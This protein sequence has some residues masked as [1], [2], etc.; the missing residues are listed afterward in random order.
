MDRSEIGPYLGGPRATSGWPKKP[1]L[2][3]RLQRPPGETKKTPHQCTSE[4]GRF[5]RKRHVGEHDKERHS[6]YSIPLS[7]SNT[8]EPDRRRPDRS[9]IGPYLGGPR[10]T[11][12]WPKKPS[13]SKRLQRPPG[14]TKKTPHQCTSEVGRFLRKRHVGEH[15][16][17]RHSPYSIPLSL[18]NTTEPDRRR[19]D[20]SEIGPYLGSPRATSGWPKKPC[21]PTH[22]QRPPR[23]TKKPTSPKHLR[24]GVFE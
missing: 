11:S 6:P 1:S 9:E 21:L 13:L 17:E 16:K 2:S 10:A 22:F 7:L 4:V 8:T 19:P 12:G 3:K 14:E 20:R 5:L 24:G 15:D 18:S 23:E